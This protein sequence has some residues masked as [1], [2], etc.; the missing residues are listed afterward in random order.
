MQLDAVRLNDPEQIEQIQKQAK[1]NLDSANRWTD[2]IWGVKS[3]LVK[4]KGMSGKEVDKQLCIDANFDY[5]MAD[6]SLN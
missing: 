1:V 2:N 4:K 5:L 6:A 3:Y